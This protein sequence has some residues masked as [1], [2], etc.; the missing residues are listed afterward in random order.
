MY[1]YKGI[2]LRNPEHGQVGMPRIRLDVVLF[3]GVVGEVRRSIV[4][5]ALL[6]ASNRASSRASMMDCRVVVRTLDCVDIEH[7]R[8]VIPRL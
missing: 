1:T 5:A 3:P 2:P 6:G 7:Q 8:T 4:I